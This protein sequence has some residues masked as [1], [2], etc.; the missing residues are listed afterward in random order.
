MDAKNA[1]IKAG[2]K[3]RGAAAESN[4]STLIRIHKVA[5]A[6]ERGR[7]SAADKAGVTLEYVID[8]LKDV[9]DRCMEED[10][11]Q[12]TGANR[13]LELLGKHLGAFEKDNAQ[14]HIS[15][16]DI[17]A[18][19]PKSFAKSVCKELDKLVSEKSD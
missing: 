19:L 3:S 12:P 17:L 8:G 5:A 4:S 7:K 16:E 6:I 10:S 2:Y 13:A 9:A 11:L 15:L 18:A 14:K 1:Y